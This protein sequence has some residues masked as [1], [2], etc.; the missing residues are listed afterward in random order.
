MGEGNDMGKSKK[1]LLLEYIKENKEVSSAD[2]ARWGTDNFYTSSMRRAR[3]YAEKGILERFSKPGKV[4]V[5]FRYAYKPKPKPEPEPEY[6]TKQ[7]TLSLG[8]I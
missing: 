6:Y 1:A 3:E 5:F 4:L 2:I 7:Q 8:G